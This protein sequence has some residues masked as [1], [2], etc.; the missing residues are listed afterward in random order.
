MNLIADSGST[1]TVWYLDE[2]TFY[3]T[4]GFNPVLLG[5]KYI[6]E[7]IKQ[8]LLPQIPDNIQKGLKFVHFYGAGCAKHESNSKM[9]TILEG[10]FP[11][12]RVSVHSDM[13]AAARAACGYS[14]GLVGILGTGCD[15][16]V[17]DGKNI[18]K[19]A[20]S[21]GYLLGDE[22][23]GLDIG[24][25]LVKNYFYGL[26]PADL[27]QIFAKKHP[28]T[29]AELL[30]NLYQNPTPNKYLASFAEFAIEYQTHPFILAIIKASFEQFIHH[31]LLP[32]REFGGNIVHFI[33]SI[34]YL[35]Q[36]P[37]K[38]Q[39]TTHNLNLGKVL[40]TPFPDLLKY[41]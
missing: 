33:G 18:V 1:K 24:R 9:Q 17:Y 39:L 20:I 41:H 40:K 34:A 7:G 25:A 8:Q 2:R 32:N 16:C 5:E 11:N 10:I 12:S 36:K 22:G 3:T 13:L 14:A 6:L 29:E 35:L 27:A 15:A 4:E 31:H 19:N 26:F 30:V 21:L 37:L 23:A 38:E 28:I